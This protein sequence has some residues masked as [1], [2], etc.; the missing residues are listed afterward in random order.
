[1]TTSVARVWHGLTREAN[2]A[3]YLRHVE[4]KGLTSYRAAQGNRGAFVLHR[5]SNGVAEFFVISFW[6]SLDSIRSFVGSDD[7]NQAIYFPEDR[8]L[9]LCPEPEVKHYQI[10]GTDLASVLSFLG[11]LEPG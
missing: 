9:L 5:V 6:D 10:G 3:V 4:T 8:A 11:G 1:M 2:A 7:V